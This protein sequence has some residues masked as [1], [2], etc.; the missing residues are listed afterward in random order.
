MR[1]A[2]LEKLYELAGRDKNVLAL[3]SDNG[4]IVYDKFRKDF[5]KQ[6]INYGISEASM[7]ASAA[8]LASC[9]KIP[10]AYTITNFLTM[11]AFEFIRNDVC[12]QNENVKLVGIGAGFKY[13]VLGPTHHGTEDIAI[14]RVLPNMTILSPASPKEAKKATEAAYN[15][16]GPVYIRLAT[17]NDV[18]IYEEDYD[19]KVGKGTILTEGSDLAI[20]AT[21]AIVVEAL[22]AVK[23]LESE[24]IKVKLVNMSTIKPIDVDL[25]VKVAEETKA[26]IT[27]EE[28]N[29]NGG[30]GSA[31]SEVLLENYDGRVLFKRMGLI[32]FSKGYGSYDEM[33]EMNGLSKKHINNCVKDIYNKKASR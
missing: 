23:E 3:I 1:N 5:S 29:I 28:H 11:R 16:K 15:I 24:G 18:E 26:I 7:V 21:G 8:G 4:A 17:S 31:V 13:S 2:Y 10:F 33:K 30:L 14:M 25:I 12:L 19:F 20:I 6:Y 32:D 27:I 22:N 9:G